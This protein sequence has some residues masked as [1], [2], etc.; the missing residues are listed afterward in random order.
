MNLNEYLDDILID[1]N[2]KKI[3]NVISKL[4]FKITTK[5]TEENKKKI[6]DISNY[7]INNDL[8]LYED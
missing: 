5:L 6:L 8:T 3:N 1:V 7:L 4:D 2:N